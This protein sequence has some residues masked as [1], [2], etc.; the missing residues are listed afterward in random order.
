MSK[1]TN[2]GCLK[3]ILENPKKSLLVAKTHFWIETILFLIAA[4][5]LRCVGQ[6]L[7]NFLRKYF[8]SPGSIY[9]INIASKTRKKNDFIA[10]AVQELLNMLRLNHFISSFEDC[11]PS[12]NPKSSLKSKIQ[13]IFKQHK[14]L[15]HPPS[16]GNSH[17]PPRRYATLPTTFKAITTCLKTHHVAFDTSSGLDTMK[18]KCY[19]MESRMNSDEFNFYA[20][21]Q[22]SKC[23]FWL[24]HIFRW[25]ATNCD[26][27][28]ANHM[29][30]VVCNTC[31][32]AFRGVVDAKGRIYHPETKALSSIPCDLERKSLNVM[33]NY[34]PITDWNSYNQSTNKQIE[35]S[36]NWIKKVKAKRRK[37]KRKFVAIE[38]GQCDEWQQWPD[39]KEPKNKKRRLK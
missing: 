3:I 17:P 31:Q 36:G 13:S 8:I 33:A 23:D 28:C 9:E 34:L 25:N 4:H 22:Y 12:M 38:K 5:T 1:T 27:F 7:K 16:L 30:Y 15:P 10:D 29:H 11:F 39:T 6:E 19:Y 18:M 37:R 32:H 26:P 2:A 14:E 24:N 35:I 21:V 20:L